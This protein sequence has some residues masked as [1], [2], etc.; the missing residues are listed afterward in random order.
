MKDP[1]KPV[2]AAPKSPIPGYRL[3]Q[4]LGRGGFGE[5]WEAENPEGAAVALKFVSSGSSDRAAHEIRAIQMVRQLS[6][7]NLV[8][9]DKTW[10]LPGYVVVAMELAECTLED[11]CDAYQVDN[12][13]PMPLGQLLEPLAEAAAAVDFLNSRV[14]SFKG[15]PVAI[16]HGDVK[17]SN[18]LVFGDTVKLSDFHLATTVNRYANLHSRSGT[19]VYTA[20]EVL[21]GWLSDQADQFALGVTYC[22]LRG[23]RLPFGDPPEGPLRN[24]VRPAPD[25]SMLSE[26]ERPIIAR[27][28]DPTP[29]HR[30]KSCSE[31]VGRLR[32]LDYLDVRPCEAPALTRRSSHSGPEN[33]RQAARFPCYIPTTQRLLGQEQGDGKAYIRNISRGG[34]GLVNNRGFPRGTILFVEPEK[35]SRPILVRV[36][37][38]IE[39]AGGDWLLGCTFVRKLKDEE[40]HSLLTAF[41]EQVPTAAVEA[42]P[43]HAAGSPQPAG[44]I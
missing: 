14:H 23:G 5:V 13:T 24:Y 32:N 39:Q 20:P 4:F 17:P 41:Q 21:Q 6:H 26:E 40:M 27:A 22:R 42:G 9:V 43:T 35:E 30:W 1:R 8:R 2:E 18:L 29:T 3:G 37:R 28:L 33:R 19:S 44:P 38:V 31:L 7:P 15:H 34:I 10:C 12:G 36:V 11:L 25:L 16:Q